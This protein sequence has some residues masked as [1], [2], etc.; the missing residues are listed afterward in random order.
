M[1]EILMYVLAAGVLLGGIDQLLGNKRG[2]GKCLEEG[3]MLMGPTAL[4]MVGMLCLI[5]LISPGIPHFCGSH[6]YP[7]R[8]GSLGA[9]RYSGY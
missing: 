2:Y 7:H 8:R 5:P 4:S 1:N 6:F 9:G 3:F